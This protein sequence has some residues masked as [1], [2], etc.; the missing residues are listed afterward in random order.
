MP[1]DFS[2][3][4]RIA[5]LLKR[6][7][8][9]IIQRDVN[10][11]RTKMIT[12]SEVSVA[13]DLSYAKVYISPVGTDDEKAIKD[14]LKGLKKASGYIRHLLRDAVDLRVIPQLHFVY[15]DSI[16]RGIHLSQLIDEA[17]AADEKVEN[18]HKNN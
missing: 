12:I 7:I 15:D 6:Q 3:T 14:T 5:G 18:D 9:L 16:N 1:K 4:Q 13:K 11:P 2:R 17:I 8:A 10:D